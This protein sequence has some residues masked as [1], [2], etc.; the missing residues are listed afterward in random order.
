MCCVFF[1]GATR[2]IRNT[3]TENTNVLH[4][5]RASYPIEWFLSTPSQQ[6]ISEQQAHLLPV[7]HLSV[8][9][10]K[11]LHEQFLSHLSSIAFSRCILVTSASRGSE[12]TPLLLTLGTGPV[13]ISLPITETWCLDFPAYR[14]GMVI[15]EKAATPKMIQGNR[16]VC[17]IWSSLR[18]RGQIFNFN[19]QPVDGLMV[20]VRTTEGDFTAKPA[21]P[22]VLQIPGSSQVSQQRCFW[23]LSAL[24]G[25]MCPPAAS[26][27]CRFIIFSYLLDSK[28]AKIDHKL[29]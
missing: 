17:K 27:L 29:R 22:A 6:F 25:E 9:P 16:S 18:Q 13:Q 5:T 2:E 11:T 8:G 1:L 15:M 12:S 21:I 28:K 10:D 3:V 4:S 7:P 23:K 26:A 20:C 24:L 14:L 19:L